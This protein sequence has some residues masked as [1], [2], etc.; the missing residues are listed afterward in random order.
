MSAAACQI[1]ECGNWGPAANQASVINNWCRLVIE[2]AMLLMVFY[3][4]FVS[5]RQRNLQPLV[6]TQLIMLVTFYL[7]R[8]YRNLYVVLTAD[9]S[10]EDEQSPMWQVKANAIMVTTFFLQHWLFTA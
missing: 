10:F 3:T 4:I 6:V 9:T 2:L 5:I 1:P 8:S 7:Y